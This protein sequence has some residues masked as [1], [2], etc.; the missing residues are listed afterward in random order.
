MADSLRFDYTEYI[1][2]LNEDEAELVKQFYSE[3]YNADFYSTEDHVLKDE[4]A[5]KEAHRN[6]NNRQRDALVVGLKA[7]IL[8][9]LT[10]SQ[11]EFMQ[12][13]SDNWEWQNVFKLMG[14]K[15]AA[16][17]ILEQCKRDLENE[18][19]DINVTLLR[20]HSKLSELRKMHNK[21]RRGK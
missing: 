17:L 12:E 20:F 11:E 6:K 7:G 10:K 4:E 15:E 18:I 16:T 14:F 2:Q 9:D 19:I 3:Y 13:A 5:I 1:D 21:D 8:D